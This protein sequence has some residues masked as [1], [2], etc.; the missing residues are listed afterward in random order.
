[1][2]TEWPKVSEV[3][4]DNSLHLKLDELVLKKTEY[5]FA[6]EEAKKVP[7]LK[8]GPV[9]QLNRLGNQEFN[10]FGL[11]FIMPLPFTDRNQGMRQVSE[12]NV[13]RAKLEADF[14]RGQRDIELDFRKKRYHE[15][16]EHLAVS[17]DLTKYNDLVLEYKS[18]FRRGLIS[19]PSFL[20]FKRELTN[21]V[22]EVHTLEQELASHYLQIYHLS[23]KNADHSYLKALNL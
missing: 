6:R 5:E 13:R 2:D 8:I 14:N 10:I 17:G 21:L 22:V 20:A 19:I 1:V 18:L 7:D 12:V 3:N 11:G 15:L 23:A 4:V 9:W 16:L